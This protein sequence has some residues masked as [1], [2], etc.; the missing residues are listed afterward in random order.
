MILHRIKTIMYSDNAAANPLVRF[1]LYLVSKAYGAVTQL[2]S[3]GYQRGVLASKKLPCK[4]ISF[5]NLTVGGTGKTPLTLYTAE[6]LSLAGYR[7]V[8]LS[9]G[10]KGKAE[11]D[12][13]VVSDGHQI[14]LNS[15]QAGDEPFMMAARLKKFQIPV[16]VGKDRYKM[17][18]L[19]VGRFKPEI[20]ICDDAYQHLRLQR[21]LNFLLIDHHR[22][23]GN[24]HIFPRGTMR[25]PKSAIQRADALIVTRSEPT[26]GVV[27][28]DLQTTLDEWASGKPIFITRHVPHIYR[29][30]PSGANLR[31]ITES[32]PACIENSI[33]ANKSVFAFSGIARND[34]FKATVTD[35]GAE[36]L[37]F[38][39]FSD[40]H[41]Y[42]I[43]DL[44]RIAASASNAGAQLLVTTEK[45]YVK[46]DPSYM[47]PL[48]LVVVGIDIDFG[49]GATRFQ[50]FIQERLRRH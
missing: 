19:A 46:I 21:D 17:G 23:F 32:A 50:S 14:R 30:I 5:G 18:M 28:Q 36:L 49:D 26:D 43:N 44:Q 2:R 10:Y 48:D 41:F 37:G 9:R 39:G 13:A 15:R 42:T 20:I 12:G 34:E 1:S 4:V 29:L 45:D 6:Q 3:K 24:S 40:H 35:M 38:V 27:G 11:R 25:E 22:P 31:G 7:I 8:V 47:T 33:L 16:I